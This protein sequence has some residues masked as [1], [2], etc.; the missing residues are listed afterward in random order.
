MSIG[1]IG[2]SRI[3][4]SV[5]NVVLNVI[6]REMNIADAIDAPRTHHQW[7]PDQI[8]YEPGLSDDTNR[9]V[10]GK[11]ATSLVPLDWYGRASGAITP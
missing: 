10:K 9:L 3:I 8:Y 6:D 11:K 7:L 4:T 1:A 5:L 2:G